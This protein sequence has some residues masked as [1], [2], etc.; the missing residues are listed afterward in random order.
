MK[1]ILLCV[2]LVCALAVDAQQ[3]EQITFEESIHDFGVIKEA[4]GSVIYEFKF[5]NN[6]AQPVK[7]L[8][9]KASCGC[10][11][12]GWSKESITPGQAGYIKAQY[13]TKNR[14]GAFNKSLTV[15]TDLITEQTK[16]L[17]IKGQ[18]TPKPKSIDEEF[19]QV[20]GG[21][22]VKYQ[23][24]NLGKVKMVD[25]PTVRKYEVYNA[26][27]SSISF[28]DQV[29]KPSYINVSFDPQTLPAKTKG[30]IVL[31]YDAKNR[32]D[33]GFVS[34]NV[35]I[36]TDEVNEAD[37]SF[38]VYATIEEYFPKMSKEALELAPSLAIEKMI[39]DFGKI[40]QGEKVKTIFTLTNS[41]KQDLN[42]R[43]AKSTCGCV[44]VKLKKTTIKPG[45][46][47]E[48]ELIFDSTDRRGIQQ[49]SV[50]IFTNDPKRSA[51]RVTIKVSVRIE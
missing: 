32:N 49:K 51:Q 24:F 27:D 10:T 7:I 35:V 9:V 48:L 12:P 26:S 19:P 14:P 2:L 11:T 5:I 33:Y 34:D 21:L 25:E 6:G 20:I 37:K 4:N 15:T 40:K 13:N 17:Y 47:T 36:H 45:K 39:H 3:A 41:G 29:D 8:N 44:I 28:L 42:I 16:K 22:R 23:S 31:S 30:A 43:K 38:S 50:S 1:T 18:V 46:S